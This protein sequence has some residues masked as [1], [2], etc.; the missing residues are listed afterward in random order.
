M[1]DSITPIN[2]PPHLAIWEMWMATVAET[3]TAANSELL[4]W[5][6]M[7]FVAPHHHDPEEHFQIDVPEPFEDDEDPDLFA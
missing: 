6:A 4:H 3:M 2:L 5:Y 1:T 7:P